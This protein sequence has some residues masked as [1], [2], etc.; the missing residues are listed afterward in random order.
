MRKAGLGAWGVRKARTS[1]LNAHGTRTAGVS[2]VHSRQTMLRAYASVLPDPVAAPASRSR[3]CSTTGRHCIWMG[4]GVAEPSAVTLAAIGP[5]SSSAANVSAGAGTSNPA[6]RR[7]RAR[8]RARSEKGQAG[9][10]RVGQGRARLRAGGATVTVHGD[11]E[12]GPR[13]LG[14]R[15]RGRAAS[16]LDVDVA[17][18]ALAAAHVGFGDVA[19]VLA[20]A[21]ADHAHGL[22]R[23]RHPLIR[24]PLLHR[25]HP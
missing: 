19:D 24:A 12:A 5:G 21:A 3:P 13:R 18:L 25:R 9:S 22:A 7:P 1:R 6:A 10:G 16:R 15:V 20:V 8:E 11:A 23:P 17:L 14:R 4:V 2:R